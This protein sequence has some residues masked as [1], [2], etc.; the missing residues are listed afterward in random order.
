MTGNSLGA[1]AGAALFARLVGQDIAGARRTP[2]HTIAW[3]S[4]WPLAGISGALGFL[5]NK[6]PPGQYCLDL[7]GMQ[8]I[9]ECR[10]EIGLIESQQSLAQ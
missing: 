5:E 2:E 1:V 10:S 4:R 3:D 9:R 7:L 6:I 8:V